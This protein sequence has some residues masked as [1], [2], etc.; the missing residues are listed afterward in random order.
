MA[1]DDRE[2]ELRNWRKAV[3]SHSQ[4]G[5]RFLRVRLALHCGRPMPDVTLGRTSLTTREGTR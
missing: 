3:Q 2:R 5:S 4:L 1:A